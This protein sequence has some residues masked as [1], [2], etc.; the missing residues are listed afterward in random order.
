MRILRILKP[1]VTRI[2]TTVV[3][4]H[5]DFACNQRLIER[6]QRERNSLDQA[7]TLGVRPSIDLGGSD[8]DTEASKSLSERWSDFRTH[9]LIN[10]CIVHEYKFTDCLSYTCRMDQNNLPWKRI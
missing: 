7:T 3:R 8:P 5:A 1:Q 6:Q 4:G 2:L 9:P 10:G